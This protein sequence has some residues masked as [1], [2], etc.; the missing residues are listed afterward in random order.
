[1]KKV[2]VTCRAGMGTSTMLA[3]QVSNVAKK[4]NWDLDV[5]HTSLDGIG[6]FHSD[7]IVALSDVADDIKKQKR[8]IDVIGIKNMMDQQEIE[9]KLAP[10]MNE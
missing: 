6:S 3:V 4:N 1:M 10:L 8:S 2:L 9:D 7:I 5:N